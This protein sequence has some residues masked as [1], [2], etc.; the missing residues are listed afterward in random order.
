[1]IAPDGDLRGLSDHIK[2]LN[3]ETISPAGLSLI[4]G[5]DWKKLPK[6]DK[7]QRIGPCVSRPVNFVCIGL[8]Y[9]DHAA[10]TNSPIPAEPILFLKSLSA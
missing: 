8:N 9:A 7:A 2:D 6:L 3:G 10:E 4:A 1:M 5:L